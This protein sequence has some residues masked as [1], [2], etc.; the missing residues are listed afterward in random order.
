MPENEKTLHIA[1]P[2]RIVQMGA[3]ALAMLALFLVVQSLLGLR[4][5]NHPSTPAA[6]TITVTGEG[7]ATAVPDVAKISY[8]VTE[9]AKSVGDAQTAATTK[10]NAALSALTGSGIQDKD[11]KTLSYN[12]SPQYSYSNCAPGVFCPNTSPTITG[13][14]VSQTIQVTVHDTSKAGDV[15]QKLG[16]LGVQNI[17]GPSFTVDDDNTV[18]A[19]ARADAI[20]KAKTS[21]DLLAKQ[22]GV[23]LG[24]I[25]NFYEDNGQSPQPYGVTAMSAGK[26]DAMVAPTLPVGQNE[27]TSSVSIT[28]EID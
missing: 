8:T 10:S 20:A 26:S 14:E 11:V 22:L 25:V 1:P 12:V 4:E 21:A 23:H 17:S 24:R 28:Y 9:S 5:L 7:S 16:T 27:T 19:E 15:L 18:K 3:I 13:Y 6:D 2:H